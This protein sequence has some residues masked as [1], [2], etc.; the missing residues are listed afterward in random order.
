MQLDAFEAA[1]SGWNAADIDLIKAALLGIVE[2]LTEFCR[3]R[4]PG[5]CC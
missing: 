2:G 1:V 5:I 3:F 4:R